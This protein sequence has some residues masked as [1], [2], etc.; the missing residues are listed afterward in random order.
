MFWVI[1]LVSLAPI[2]SVAFQE[3]VPLLKEAGCF[4]TIIRRMAVPLIL[5]YSSGRAPCSLKGEK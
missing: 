2:V 4:Y 3:F 5:S 1:G